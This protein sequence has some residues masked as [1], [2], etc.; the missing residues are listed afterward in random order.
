MLASRWLRESQQLCALLRHVVE[1][2]LAG[3]TDGLKEYSLGREVFHR[4]PDY[5]PRSDAIV[6]VQASLLRKRLA[7][8]Y[9]HE[10]HGARLQ[11]QL[12]RGGY[13]PVFETVAEPPEAPREP[14]LPHPEA[15]SR[16]GKRYWSWT[17]FVAGVVLTSLVALMLWHRPQT[18]ARGQSA[19]PSVW[20]AFLRPGARTIVGFGVPLFYT[21]RG[22]YVRD[23]DVNLPG[24]EAHGQLAGMAKQLDRTFVPHEDVYTGIGE[25]L[26]VHAVSQWLERNGQEVYVANSRFVGQSDFQNRN[27]VIVSSARFQTILQQLNLPHVYVFNH[28]GE[29]GYTLMNA[30]GNAVRTFTSQ[31]IGGVNTSYAVISLWP[32]LKPD[33]RILEA[34]GIHSWSTLGA[35]Q[36][37]LNDTKMADLQ[38]KLDADPPDGRNGKKSPYFEVL[39]RLEGKYD[40]VRAVEYVEHHYLPDIGRATPR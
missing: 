17:P 31:G 23:V 28:S 6:R 18:R 29:G 10:G 37:L 39:L 25:S 7:S 32:G 35:T 8:Y 19:S 1:A 20:G 27:L 12:P 9:E 11:I 13:V 5:D 34:S 33:T 21:S 2:T 26:G 3:E 36:F 30:Q 24:Q 4:P 22:I 40:Q 15:E 38:R 14:I 16:P